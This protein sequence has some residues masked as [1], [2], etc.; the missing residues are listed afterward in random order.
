MTLVSTPTFLDP[1][2]MCRSLDIEDEVDYNGLLGLS[3]CLA[4][5]FGEDCLIRTAAGHVI[6]SEATSGLVRG[7]IFND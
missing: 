3:I 2:S 5:M 7:D 4:V 1:I 6:T